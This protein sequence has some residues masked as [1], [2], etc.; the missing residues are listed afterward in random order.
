METFVNPLTALESLGFSCFKQTL[1]DNRNKKLYV[2]FSHSLKY[3]VI[4]RVG[5]PSVGKSLNHIVE[6][7]KLGNL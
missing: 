5:Y 7:Y 6:F 1:I 4:A 3:G 2:T